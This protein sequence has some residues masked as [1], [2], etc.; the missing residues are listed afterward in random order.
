MRKKILIC[1]LVSAVIA[2][3]LAVLKRHRSESSESA[4]VQLK[5]PFLRAVAK[6]AK[7]ESLEAVVSSGGA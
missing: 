3:P 7:K 4:E 2:S 1:L 6:T 5:V